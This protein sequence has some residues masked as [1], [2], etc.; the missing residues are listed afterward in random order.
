MVFN[1]LKYKKNVVG[2]D[3]SGDEIDVFVTKKYDKPTAQRLISNPNVDFW[4]KDLVPKKMW[5]GF[6]RKKT[7]VV[8][9][10]ELEAQNSRIYKPLKGGCEI[11]KDGSPYVGTAGGL[12]YRHKYKNLLLTGRW[13][14]FIDILKHF[15]IPYTSDKFIL[16][17]TH[18]AVP[19]IRYDGEYKEIV[20]PGAWVSGHRKIGKTVDYEPIK[21]NRKNT[22]DA[23]LIKLEEDMLPEQIPGWKLNGFNFNYYKDMKIKKY[24]RTTGAT[25]GYIL[26]DNVTTYIN[27]KSGSMQFKG[28]C[29]ATRMSD[30]GDSGSLVLDEDNKI[31]GLH[32]AG[33]PKYSIFIPIE[34]IVKR[35]NLSTRYE[36]NV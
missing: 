29:L 27:Y 36:D 35:F 9:V 16:T 2:V 20:Q 12:V 19:D 21:K 6:R 18:V 11:S 22:M 4:D 24:G 33:G 32:F 5:K 7:N 31:V 13:E 3:D 34:R 15:G 8:E 17:N 30:K 26:Y 10:G 23:A 14:S 1:K 25:E 28:V